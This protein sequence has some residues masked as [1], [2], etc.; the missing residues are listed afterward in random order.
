M[1]DIKRPQHDITSLATSG[2]RYSIRF[3]QAA[4]ECCF[5]RGNSYPGAPSLQEG[6]QSLTSLSQSPTTH[7]SNQVSW[8]AC[9]QAGR[10]F[11]SPASSQSGRQAGRQAGKQA[12]EQVSMPVVIPANR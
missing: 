4:L 12:G 10:Q 6:W 7:M 8:Q 11:N 2:A 3:G 5:S 9:R 1:P